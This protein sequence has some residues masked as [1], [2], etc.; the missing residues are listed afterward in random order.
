MSAS[1]PEL[2]RLVGLWTAKAQADLCLAE[3][4]LELA[5]PCPFDLV[6]YHAQQCAEKYVKSYLVSRQIDFPYSHDLRFL[7]GM[8]EK[9]I[10]APFCRE[11]SALSVHASRTRYPF[12]APDPDR[13]E[14]ERCVDLSREVKQAVLALLQ[15]DGFPIARQA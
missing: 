6:C 2:V 7:T 12:E 15:N 5:D 13:A 14:A 8:I 4:A 11:T 9:I 1:D 10:G 3:L